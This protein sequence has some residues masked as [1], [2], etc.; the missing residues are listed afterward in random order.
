MKELISKKLRP[1]FL[2]GYFLT[3]NPA[4]ISA[5]LIPPSLLRKRACQARQ[6]PSFPHVSSGNPDETRTGPLIKTFGGDAFGSRH[7]VLSIP[8]SLLRGVSI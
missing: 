8:S 4:P 2:E 1:G 3:L 7:S 5:G 6:S